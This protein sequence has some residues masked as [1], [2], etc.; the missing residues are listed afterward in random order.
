MGKARAKVSVSLLDELIAEKSFVLSKAQALGTM[1]LGETVQ[2]LWASAALLEERIA[3][4]L[5]AYGEELEA[6]VHRISAA[7]CYEKAGDPSRATNLYRAALAGPLREVTRKDVEGM[8][9]GC[10]AR[11]KTSAPPRK[12]RKAASSS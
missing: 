4:L 3:S 1:E 6:A 9:A 5:D 8:L 10:L 11:L 7:S 2:P 12:P